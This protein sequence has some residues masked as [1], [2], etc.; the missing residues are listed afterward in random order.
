MGRQRLVRREG[1]AAVGICL[2]VSRVHK[3]ASSLPQ[4]P[5]APRVYRGCIEGVSDP[6]PALV[7]HS[8]YSSSVGNSIHESA[9]K[10][11]T[12]WVGWTGPIMH[13][14]APGLTTLGWVGGWVGGGG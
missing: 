12:G 7:Y 13:A 11:D 4:C 6:S 10:R 14:M 9:K 8:R 2:M 3:C 5:S 1:R